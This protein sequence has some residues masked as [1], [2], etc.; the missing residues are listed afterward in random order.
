MDGP[1]KRERL[2][3]KDKERVK[4]ENIRLCHSLIQ[5]ILSYAYSHPHSCGCSTFPN[6]KIYHHRVKYLGMWVNRFNFNMIFMW[7]TS[8]IFSLVSNVFIQVV[9]KSPVKSLVHRHTM[10][11][12]PSISPLFSLIEDALGQRIH[13]HLIFLSL[14]PKTLVWIFLQY[15]AR[16]MVPHGGP[17]VFCP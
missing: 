6:C 4:S 11:R 9:D 1:I 12:C 5:S 8:K 15:V 14:C 2:V 16:G 7:D 10:T 3:K 13:L 17:R